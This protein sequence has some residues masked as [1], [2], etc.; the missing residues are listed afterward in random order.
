[1]THFEKIKE[2]I[3]AASVEELVGILFEIDDLL[4]VC[5]LC[6]IGDCESNC[7]QHCLDWLNSPVPDE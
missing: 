2:Q 7:K 6:E 4:F 1:M 5:K 3:A